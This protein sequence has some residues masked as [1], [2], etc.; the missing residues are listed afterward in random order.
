MR[1]RVSRCRQ[2][3][4]GSPGDAY[5]RRSVEGPPSAD[6]PRHAEEAY[7][8]PPAGGAQGCRMSG[9]SPREAIIMARRHIVEGGEKRIARQEARVPEVT[10]HGYS[11]VTDRSR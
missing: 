6:R 2:H 3:R 1:R 8:A 11:Q 4:A 7:R 5:G 10:E 9:W